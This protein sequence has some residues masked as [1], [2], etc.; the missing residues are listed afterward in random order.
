MTI[1]DH[2]VSDKRL[3]VN[4]RKKLIPVSQ[5]ERSV[6]FDRD[7]FSLSHVLQKSSTGII[8][9]HKRRSPSKSVINNDLNVFEVA[10]GYEVAG[11]N[12]MSVLTDGKYF[13]GSLDDLLIAR[14]SCNL[15]LLRK[16]FIIDE[17][18][19]LEAKS[20][21]ADVILLI[22][23]ILTRDE[24]KQFSELAKDLKM[25]VLLEV[26]NEG[27]LNK[28]IMPSLDMIG[29]NNR[30]L[31][32]FE[33]SLE[34]SKSLSEKIPV[35]FIKVSESGISSVEAIKELRPYGYK[36][37]LIGENFMKTNNPGVSAD[38]FIKKLRS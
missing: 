31:K 25:D 6:L 37:F 33:V 21:G 35:D 38:K 10:K 34:T 24:I 16:E 17:Y 13:G 23:A 14:S 12:G 11:V 36:G 4:L 8:A 32:T 27:E 2:I 28:S 22:A 5:L 7:T 1:L 26:H 20:Y 30:N 9:E 29:V 19:I 3:E 18:Q 15:P